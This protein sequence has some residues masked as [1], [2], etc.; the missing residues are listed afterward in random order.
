LENIENFYLKLIRVFLVIFATI[1]LIYAL[2]NLITSVSDII[3]EPELEQVDL[4]GWS[5]LR[6]EILP[7]KK[8]S[9]EKDDTIESKP[10]DKIVDDG[11]LYESELKL[12]IQN[13]KKLFSDDQMMIFENNLNLQYLDRYIDNIPNIYL[14]NFINGM[15]NLASDLSEDNLLK[16]IEDPGRKVTLIKDSFDLYKVTFFE[17]LN[18]VETSNYQAIQNSQEINAE[19]YSNIIFTAY[20]LGSFIIFLLYILILKVEYNLRK[21]APAISSK[22]Q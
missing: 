13:L 3:D 17:R 2:I 12:V 15:V 20:A 1:A 19:G 4:P 7:I 16:R 9:E 5:D 8:S 18:S 14:E 6:Y 21:I 11:I 22:D 10:P